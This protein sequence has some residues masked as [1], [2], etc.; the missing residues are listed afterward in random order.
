MV[1]CPQPSPPVVR[2]AQISQ[3]SSDTRQPPR[4]GATLRRMNVHVPSPLWPSDPPRCDR[5]IRQIWKIHFNCP[6][7]ALWFMEIQA[8]PPVNEKAR[9]DFKAG[10]EATRFAAPWADSQF[11]EGPHPLVQSVNA[12]AVWLFVGSRHGP[13]PLQL[14]QFPPQSAFSMKT[15]PFPHLQRQPCL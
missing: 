3:D 7:R 15:V 4:W 13:R 11:V 5:A 2:A 12:L 1:T 9:L 8:F 6:D 14:A 10:L